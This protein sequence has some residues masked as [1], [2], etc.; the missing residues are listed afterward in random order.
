MASY[1]E[2]GNASPAATRGE[3]AAAAASAAGLPFAGVDR[4]PV[5]V[6]EMSPEEAAGVIPRRLLDAT[7]ER[8]PLRRVVGVASRRA[9]AIR[10]RAAAPCHRLRFASVSVDLFRPPP[11]LVGEPPLAPRGLE[12]SAVRRA[13]ALVFAT[14]I[15]RRLSLFLDDS[16]VT[17]S[18]LRAFLPAERHLWAAVLAAA[19]PLPLLCFPDAGACLGLL[20]DMG[21]GATRDAPAAMLTSRARGEG[22]AARGVDPERVTELAPRLVAAG[23]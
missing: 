20:L 16:W 12:R 4:R 17:A 5:G 13:A 8:P 1:R 2:L 23:C 10:C 3:D 21:G 9:A 22:D 19:M 18:S 15:F 6:A 7:D 11:P 14:S